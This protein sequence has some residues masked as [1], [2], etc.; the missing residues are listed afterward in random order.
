MNSWGPLELANKS[1]H[2]H[3]HSGVVVSLQSPYFVYKSIGPIFIIVGKMNKQSLVNYG[4]E[5]KNFKTI[6]IW[7]TNFKFSSFMLVYQIWVYEKS[8]E[9]IVKILRGVLEIHQK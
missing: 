6:I 5:H 8:K 9:V 7:E 2:H 1:L 3:F 4:I